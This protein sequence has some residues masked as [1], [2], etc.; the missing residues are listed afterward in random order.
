MVS[1]ACA[2][3]PALRLLL[4]RPAALFRAAPRRTSSRQV[5]CTLQPIRRPGYS[6]LSSTRACHP[7]QLIPTLHPLAPCVQRALDLMP[8]LF[9][10]NLE[11]Y[12][13]NGLLRHAL[14]P[15]TPLCLAA[16]LCLATGAFHFGWP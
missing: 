10:A 13:N 5:H 3:L 6:P 11:R 2:A 8:A 15:A 12:A 14:H 9:T 1:W 7:L 16:L 4:K